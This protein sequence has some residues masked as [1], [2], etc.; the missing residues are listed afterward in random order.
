MA[1]A[2]FTSDSEKK[3]V[4][5]LVCDVNGEPTNM[6]DSDLFGNVSSAGE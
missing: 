1:G 5:D 2:V 3:L 4:R 6:L